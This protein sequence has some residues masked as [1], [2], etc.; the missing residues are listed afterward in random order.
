MMSIFHVDVFGAVWDRINSVD[1]LIFSGFRVV[2]TPPQQLDFVSLLRKC[3][4]NKREDFF[5]KW[6]SLNLILLD[7]LAHADI[8]V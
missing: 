6:G 7:V 2:F 3:V 5:S 8:Y 1:G 4:L